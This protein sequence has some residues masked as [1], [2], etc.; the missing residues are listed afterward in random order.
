MFNLKPENRIEAQSGRA[1]NID[2][3]LIPMINIVFLLLIF[4]MVS[5]QIQK[6]VSQ[7]VELTE[8]ESQE[9]YLA[10]AHQISL[11]ADG[12]WQ[13]NGQ[14]LKGNALLNQLQQARQK[15]EESSQNLAIY[16]DRFATAEQLN[17]LLRE[18]KTL[19]W[20]RVHLVTRKAN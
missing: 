7:E 10:A 9:R 13:M 18:V 5:G 20:D 12:R 16:V 2:D 11:T 4:F 1:I 6:P 3:N 19:S 14:T 17:E 8:T 15:T